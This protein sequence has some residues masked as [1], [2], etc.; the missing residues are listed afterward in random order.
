MFYKTVNDLIGT[1]R[2]ASGDGWKSR[3]FLLAEDGLPFSLH[4]TTVAAGTVLHLNYQN[5]SESVYCISGKAS[6]E[7]IS[8]NK[9]FP[10]EPG[11]F[12]T[13]GIGDEHILR[14]EEE[15]KFLCIFEPALKGIEEAD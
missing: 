10:I 2:E 14:I 15:T 1:K 12:Y 3:R 13:A 11:T 5:H 6:V 8:I 7:E 4:E 9:V